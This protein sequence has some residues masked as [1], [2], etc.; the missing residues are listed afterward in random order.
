[1]ENTPE[2]FSHTASVV[3]IPEPKI[4]KTNQKKP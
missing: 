2:K 3:G 1:M 4:Q